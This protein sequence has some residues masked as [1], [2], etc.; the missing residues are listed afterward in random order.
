MKHLPDLGI[1]LGVACMIAG[2]AWIYMPAGLILAGG[3]LIGFSILAA[4]NEH[5]R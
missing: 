3:L 2:A 1:A 4:V 5:N